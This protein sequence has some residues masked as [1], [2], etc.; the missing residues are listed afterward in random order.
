MAHF[1]YHPHILSILAKHD[2]I[3]PDTMKCI[4]EIL[5]FPFILYHN[6]VVDGL[7]AVANRLLAVAASSTD[8]LA[9]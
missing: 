5:F 6:F 9:E 1:D 3:L 4:D 8:F 7:L 2:W